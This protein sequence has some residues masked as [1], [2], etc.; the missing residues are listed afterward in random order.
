MTSRAVLAASCVAAGVVISACSDGGGDST[1]RADPPAL[2]AQPTPS[3]THRPTNQ[4][5]ISDDEIV[6]QSLE[7]PGPGGDPQ[8]TD[9]SSLTGG[10]CPR[11]VPPDAWWYPDGTRAVLWSS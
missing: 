7:V 11:E 1:P 9:P 3:P 5:A 8:F 10:P 4:R 2:S 6:C